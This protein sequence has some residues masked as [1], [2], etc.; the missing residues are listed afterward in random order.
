MEVSLNIA[1]EVSSCISAVQ[2]AT[3]G[4]GAAIV[5]CCGRWRFWEEK[6]KFCCYTYSREPDGWDVDVFYKE[7]VY[8]DRAESYLIRRMKRGIAF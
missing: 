8:L 6:K 7:D 2:L 3:S 1:M 4:L 5:P